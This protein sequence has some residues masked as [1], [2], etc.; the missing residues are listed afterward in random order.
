MTRI[1]HV[2]MLLF[3]GLGWFLGPFAR[4]VYGQDELAQFF[5]SHERGF[6]VITLPVT[7]W[8]GDLETQMALTQWL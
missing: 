4:H 3:V 5:T 1:T 2:G 8:P 7:H 6:V